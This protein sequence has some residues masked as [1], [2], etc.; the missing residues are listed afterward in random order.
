MLGINDPDLA[1]WARER[2]TQ[3]PIDTYT[4]PVPEGNEQS[5]SIPR[6]FIRCTEGPLASLFGRFADKA[7]NAG[8]QMREI[9]TGHDAMLTAPDEVARHLIELAG[10]T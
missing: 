6:A 8:W 2:I 5:A 3:H 1:E 7:R 9:E 10:A 4:Q